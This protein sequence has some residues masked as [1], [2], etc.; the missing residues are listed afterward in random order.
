MSDQAPNSAAA[1]VD[2]VRQADTAE[3][4]KAPAAAVDPKMDLYARKER[5]LQRQRQELEAE[6]QSWKQK[7]ADYETGY[8]AKDRLK[9]D[10]IGALNE[11]GITLDQ[12][13]EMLL[14][15]PNQNDPATR[16]M[17]AKIKQLEDKQSA[18]ERQAQ[19]LST[20]QYEQAKKQISNE[21][22]M[23]IDSDDE[24]ESIKSQGMHDAVAELIFETFEQTGELMDVRAAALEVENH[25]IDEGYKLAQLPKVQSR[26]KPPEPPVS[27]SMPQTA[28]KPQQPQTSLRTLTS[29][30]SAEASK[31]RSSDK[32]RMARAIAAFKGELK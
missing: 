16:A 12:L 19:E 8:V 20:R 27:A 24:F 23:L 4:V 6:R 29:A 2:A 18:S 32:E 26:L 13:T 7:Q 21:A 28:A 5:A 3:A 10:P 9:S 17:L 14:N 22:K 31:T 25:L 30:V 11:Q 15:Q 1:A